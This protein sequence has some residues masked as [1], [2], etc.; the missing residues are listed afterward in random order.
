MIIVACSLAEN[1]SILTF[2]NKAYLKIL[3]LLNP[4]IY[5]SKEIISQLTTMLS[6]NLAQNISQ[7]ITQN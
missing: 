4:E 1:K 5:L 7:I 2:V 3:M 6:I